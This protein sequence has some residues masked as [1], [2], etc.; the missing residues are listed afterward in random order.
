MALHCSLT[1]KRSRPKSKKP[2]WTA[3]EGY[4][5]IDRYHLAYGDYE[6]TSFNRAAQCIET[7]QFERSE[8]LSA[9][10]P[11]SLMVWTCINEGAS[12]A[13][14][15]T[16]A[17]VNDIEWLHDVPEHLMYRRIVW[18]GCSTRTGKDLG[19]EQERGWNK[20][21][22]PSFVAVARALTFANSR[23]L[24]DILADWI[25]ASGHAKEYAQQLWE[26]GGFI[27]P[28][29][30]RRLVNAGVSIDVELW[31]DRRTALQI[32]AALWEHDSVE[33]LLELGASVS[34]LKS[35]GRSALHWFVGGP[36]TLIEDSRSSFSDF[37]RGRKS[38]LLK[39]SKREKQ[40]IQKSRII[41]TLTLLS[42]SGP[43]LKSPLEESDEDG[44]TPLRIA[45]KGSRTAT[46]ALLD[47]GA[48]V[49]CKD[50]WGR[51]P[52]MH[53]LSGQFNGRPPAILKQL[54]DAGADT[55][56]IDTAGHTVL[57]YWERQVLAMDL[58]SL[59]AGYTSF[60]KGFD[61]LTSAGALSD[62]DV[63]VRELALTK[64]PLAAAVRMCNAK[65]CWA[66]LRAGADPN[67]HGLFSQSRLIEQNG[68]E[69]D[70]VA[71]LSWKPLMIALQS[72]AYTTAAILLAHG[73]D[74]TFQTPTRRRTKYNKY[75]RWGLTPLYVAV[76][77]CVR[78]ASYDTGLNTGG[79]GECSFKAVGNPEHKIMKK[80]GL[81]ELARIQMDSYKK[82]ETYQQQYKDVSSDV[83]L[84]SSATSSKSP[85]SNIQQS[86][87][88]I[89]HRR[90]HNDS[91]GKKLLPYDT[92]PIEIMS[93][94][95]FDDS[96]FNVVT[97]SEQTK[98]ARQLSMVELLLK[99]GAPVNAKTSAGATPLL[100]MSNSLPLANMLLSY[101]ADPNIATTNGTTPLMLFA[102][103]NELAIV[104]CLLD[105]GADPNAQLVVPP[106][107][108]RECA[109]FMATYKFHLNKCQAPLSALALA[110]ERGHYAVV[111]AL[112]KHGADPNLPIEHHVHGRLP[113]AR[114]TRRRA[115]RWEEPDSSESETEEEQF[116]GY[117]CVATAL[118][119]ARDE[120]RDLLLQ[121]GAD[122]LREQSIR[123]CDCEFIE[124]RKDRGWGGS[125]DEYPTNSESDGSDAKLR[126]RPQKIYKMPKWDG[127]NT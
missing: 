94:I 39:L 56:A 16:L 107:S 21:C 119:W 116:K 33:T 62:N 83:S 10:V 68:T 88:E 105:A 32:S 57:Q 35:N 76:G 96:L 66:L 103:A 18:K 89:P 24:F 41:S 101:G 52:L 90:F 67:K 127:D 118:T 65:L 100:S 102:A 60:N 17:N 95:Q 115:R 73:A 99:K 79:S 34:K 77:G 59:Y 46:K 104:E 121:H 85:G 80:S 30:C 28:S 114:E 122:P 91:T 42:R 92:V 27:E 43:A 7:G 75:R 51:T 25:D 113:T 50:R 1:D 8:R 54:I 13:L 55:L 23:E 97:D 87:Y 61:I 48:D 126:R 74:V 82:T 112:L 5:L 78:H 22:P 40:R 111:E 84:S 93:Q 64:V 36:E 70:E 20:S 29:F 117:I 49:E 69:A 98:E 47:A 123:E 14:K 71:D 44:K 11:I 6:Y 125:D 31:K 81:Y 53:F 9:D 120:V 110:A 106:L 72:G 124:R 109:A 38:A 19:K 15:K 4:E 58:G 37:Y 12:T 26:V 86:E 2:V 63:L 3:T 108:K 45:L